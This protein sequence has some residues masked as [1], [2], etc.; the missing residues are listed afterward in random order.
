LTDIARYRSI[1]PRITIHNWLRGRDVV[2]FL[3]LWEVLH[4]PDFKRIDTFKEEAG[5]NAFVFSIKDWTDKLGAIGLFTKSGRYGG[6][7]YAHI[8]IAFK[9]ASWIFPEFKLYHGKRGMTKLLD[10]LIKLDSSDREIIYLIRTIKSELIR[11]KLAECIENENITTAEKAWEK[12]IE[13]MKK[14]NEKP[15]RAFLDC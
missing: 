10:Q 5:T 3:G 15:R 8:D 9:F 12:S 11:Y 7:I 4:N 2:E 13:L 6:G 14:Y 1:D